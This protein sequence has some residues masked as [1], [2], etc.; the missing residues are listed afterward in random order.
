MYDAAV[1]IVSETRRCSTFVT[2]STSGTHG[3]TVKA[4]LLTKAWQRSSQS[5]SKGQTHLNCSAL[6][7]RSSRTASRFFAKLELD[8]VM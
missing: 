2:A 4:V 7:R 5:R 1:Q 6:G 3:V 8:C